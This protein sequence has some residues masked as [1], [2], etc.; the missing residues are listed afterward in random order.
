MSKKAQQSVDIV[1]NI[2]TAVFILE[3]IFKLIATGF[4]YFRDSWNIFD[5][6]I[7]VGSLIFIHPSLKKQK[8]TIVIIRGFKIGRVFKLFSKLKHL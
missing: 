2:C 6:I 7:V 5:F 8:N 3:A 1:S 4:D